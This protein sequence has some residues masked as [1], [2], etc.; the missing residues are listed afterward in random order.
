MDLKY[1]TQCIAI[2]TA[3]SQ[4][5]MVVTYAINC[6]L[7]I[8]TFKG[9]HNKVVLSLQSLTLRVDTCA[10]ERKLG[11]A[12]KTMQNDRI[13]SFLPL[14]LREKQLNLQ[15]ADTTQFCDLI[16]VA[17]ILAHKTK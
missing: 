11:T 8:I 15:H 7:Y 14:T 6:V 3:C 13:L 16:G 2:I 4:R 5:C 9:S 10:T 12:C 17:N 1:S